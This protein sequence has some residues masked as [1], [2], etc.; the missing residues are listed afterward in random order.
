MVN[1]LSPGCGC[2]DELPPPECALCEETEMG[3]VI[4]PVNRAR[5]LFEV[6]GF[7]ATH[8]SDSSS[9]NIRVETLGLDALN[10]V[11][12]F[13]WEIDFDCNDAE[14]QHFEPD[15]V[16][17]TQPA[18][19]S[20]TT[21][22]RD[23]AT[24]FVECE[25]SVDVDIIAS[26]SPAFG[27]GIDMRVRMDIDNLSVTGPSGCSSC[28]DG[29]N[30]WYGHFARSTGSNVWN[31]IMDVDCSPTLSVRESQNKWVRE[32]ASHPVSTGFGGVPNDG[33]VDIKYTFELYHDP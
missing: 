14:F 22:W 10:G 18:V 7:K 15:L 29:S 32:I 11:W 12:E 4:G 25:Q 3:G 23:F 9:P 33:T 2:C 28:R 24:C 30:L 19:A 31:V 13:V 26:A 17:Q 5:L 20:L 1:R 27:T 6:S 8:F 21:E 16:T